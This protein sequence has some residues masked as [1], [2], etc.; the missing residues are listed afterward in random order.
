MKNMKEMSYK[1]YIFENLRHMLDVLGFHFPFS[2]LYLVLYI[3]PWFIYFCG[4][5]LCHF[6]LVLANYLFNCVQKRSDF[7]ATSES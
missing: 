7:E 5:F 6:M 3:V 4:F 1:S 2:V